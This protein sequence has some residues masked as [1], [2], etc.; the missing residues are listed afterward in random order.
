[1]KYTA[2]LHRGESGRPSDP[3]DFGSGEYWSSEK[4]QARAYA[5]PEGTVRCE[6]IVLNRAA[7]LTV[8]EAYDLGEEFGTIT[9]DPDRPHTGSGPMKDRE[10]CARRMREFMIMLGYDGLVVEHKRPGNRHTIEVVMYHPE[11]TG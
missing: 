1:M 4:G 7:L 8:K 9:G 6:K 2:R 5:G 11:G 3:G 10:K